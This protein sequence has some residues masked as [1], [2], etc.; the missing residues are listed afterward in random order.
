MSRK[1]E[2][3]VV[4]HPDAILFFRISRE[5]VFQHP[6]AIS[7]IENWLIGVSEF[8]QDFTTVTDELRV[9]AG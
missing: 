6:Q 9:N 8:N 1:I 5:R 4:G 7:L 2:N 3:V